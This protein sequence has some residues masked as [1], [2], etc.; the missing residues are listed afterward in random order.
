MQNL[1]GRIK[2]TIQLASFE[3]PFTRRW[4]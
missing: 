2:R 1:L 3:M 4:E